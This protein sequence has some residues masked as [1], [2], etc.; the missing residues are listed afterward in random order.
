MGITINTLF[1]AF[2]IIAGLYLDS[3]LFWMIIYELKYGKGEE[4][5]NGTY[6]RKK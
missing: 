5:L 1:Q 6:R 3:K 2:W 4:Y